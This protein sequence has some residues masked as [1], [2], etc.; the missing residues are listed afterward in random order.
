MEIYWTWLYCEPVGKWKDAVQE[1]GYSVSQWGELGEKILELAWLVVSTRRAR[2][3]RN[4]PEF[5]VQF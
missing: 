1:S 4:S 2:F 5:Y 3:L